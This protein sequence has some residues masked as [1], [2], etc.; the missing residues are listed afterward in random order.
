MNAE[1]RADVE[2]ILAKRH[3]NG[4]D[5]WATLDGRI[6]VGGPFS[7]LASLGVSFHTPVVNGGTYR[8]HVTD[9][10]VLGQSA[11]SDQ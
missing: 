1:Y 10:G 3:S 7:T 5:F 4:G 2:A 8:L 9:W 6:Y 11:I